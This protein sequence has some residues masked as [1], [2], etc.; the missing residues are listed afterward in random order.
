MDP[1]SNPYTPNAGKKPPALVGRDSEIAGFEI[2]LKRL[3]A[4]RS[5]KSLIVTGLRGVGKTVLLGKF[6]EIA[7]A[8]SWRTATHEVTPETDIRPLMARLARSALYEISPPARWGAKAKRAAGVLKSF[9]LTFTPEGGVS[10]SLSGADQVPGKADSGDLDA[11]LTD[12][13]VELADAAADHGTGVVFLFDEVQFFDK[14]SLTALIVALHR[15]VQKDLPLTFVG[16]GL[17]QLPALAGA[18]RSYAERLFDY[19]TIG[20]LT[21]D[22]AATALVEPATE[23]GVDFEPDAVDRALDFTEG[24]PY[25]IQEVGSVVWDIADAS[26]IRRR[27]V[28]AAIPLVEK[29][30]D[31]SFFKVRAD[32]TTEL[33]LR[34]LRA[35][36]ELGPGPQRSGDIAV[37][38]GYKGSEQLGATRANLIHKGLIFTPGQGLN[39]FT[40]PQFDRYLRRTIQLERKP[41]VPR[42]K[43]D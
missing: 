13:L 17:P 19:P 43:R 37:T 2:L 20:S 33:E 24:Y 42:K 4:G 36:A 41:P 22:A 11:D 39:E 16:A 21:K 7:A 27:E 9:T 10:V 1:V 8:A 23:L 30:L 29:R 5:A 31:E 26:P 32:R 18:A 14:L 38:L 3:A 25:F 28:D 6:E 12:L 15:V 35:M 34:Y 40:V